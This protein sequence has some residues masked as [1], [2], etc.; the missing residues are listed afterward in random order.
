MMSSDEFFQSPI[1]ANRT[2]STKGAS[3][4]AKDFVS[5][6]SPSLG[7]W[8]SW[9]DSL[10]LPVGSLMVKHLN[11][12]SFSLFSLPVSL[13]LSLLFRVD[14]GQIKALLKKTHKTILFPLKV[15]E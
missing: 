4:K 11:N 3:G 5:Q 6:E 8:V 2:F 13:F 1:R 15:M 12:L 9:A 10:L 14:R 7:L